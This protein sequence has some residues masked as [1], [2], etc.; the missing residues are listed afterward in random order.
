MKLSKLFLLLCIS[1]VYFI[2]VRSAEAPQD[3]EGSSTQPSGYYLYA[4]C[5]YLLTKLSNII[6]Q[7]LEIA[8]QCG[9]LIDMHDERITELQEKTLK[10]QEYINNFDEE[11]SNK[12][13][14]EGDTGLIDQITKSLS[15]RGDDPFLFDF[16]SYKLLLDELKKV[17][18]V[19]ITQHKHYLDSG[20]F[21]RSIC[22]LAKELFCKMAVLYLM[23]SFHTD[24]DRFRQL[25]Y[26][27]LKY[28][29]LDEFH[30]LSDELMIKLKFHVECEFQQQKRTSD[31]TAHR[32]IGCCEDGQC[33][34][35]DPSQKKEKPSKKRN[36]GG[37]KK[38]M[39][40][41]ANR[42]EV[43]EPD[44][45]EEKAVLP[46]PE[47]SK[48][49]D[50]VSLVNGAIELLSDISVLEQK[51]IE[52][53]KV[54]LMKIK[55]LNKMAKYEHSNKKLMERADKIIHSRNRFHVKTRKVQKADVKKYMMEMSKAVA[56]GDMDVDI[57]K[58]NGCCHHTKHGCYDEQSTIQNPD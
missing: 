6:K 7:G 24:R 47:K 37:R 44:K 55:E 40:D 45:E 25:K 15:L 29:C 27:D 18:T 14:L 20:L 23:L 57:K 1:P 54:L 46:D 51:L 33:G 39:Q 41:E 5:L 43:P 12:I 2:Y 3:D 50:G 19:L 52:Q 13:R 32:L 38:R 21:E 28:L 49:L 34:S 10:L 26:I 48:V 42:E 56:L 16:N 53:S 30:A 17:G 8:L 31:L 36:R 4:T 9:Y 11:T 35:L 22:I 58:E